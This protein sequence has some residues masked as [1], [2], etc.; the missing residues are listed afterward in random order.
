MWYH[1]KP[2]RSLAPALE[3]LARRDADIAKAYAI[4]GLPATRNRKPGF[5]GLVRII[6]G[7][8]VSAG[9]AAAISGRLEAL[10]PD[11][12]PG[13]MLKATEARLRKAGLSRSKILYIR[14]LAQEIDCGRFDLAALERM[15]D[16]EAMAALRAHKGIGRWSAE[17][18]LLFSMKRPDI[19]PAGDLAV[20]MALKRMKRLRSVPDEKRMDRIAEPWR[21][22]RS[23]AA[24]FLWHYY[25][26]P[27]ISGV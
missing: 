10:V 6:V 13:A 2:D 3:E 24:L 23:A 22:F 25:R 17:L 1:A 4:C 26:H 16:D 14:N 5:P 7:Q 19:W 8:Q 12:T 11:I 15:P 21:P 27:G 18:Y 9:A 20:R